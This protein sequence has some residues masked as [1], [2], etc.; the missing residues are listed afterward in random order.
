MSANIS[1]KA[2]ALY[3]A[4]QSSLGTASTL[5]A[6]DI[7]RTSGLSH[8]I[9][10]GQTQTIAYDGQDGR[11]DFEKHVDFWNKYNFE[12]DLV[13]GGDDGGTDILEPPVARFLRACGWD[14]DSTVPNQRTFTLSDRSNIDAI[15]LGSTRRKATNGAGDFEVYRYDTFDARGQ[16]A[17]QFSDDRPKFVFSEFTGKY[18]RPYRIASTPLGTDVPT[19]SFVSPNPL[20]DS[21]YTTLRWKGQ[22]LCTHALSI[23]NMGWTVVGIDR[24]G[25]SEVHLNEQKI[26]IEI[27]FKQTDWENEF[28]PFQEA[29]D[30]Q[31]QN[32]ENFKL[33]CDDRVGHIFKLDATARLKNVQ[34]TDLSDGSVGVTAQLEVDTMTFGWYAE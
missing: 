21:A 11:N 10:D 18:V 6:A 14:M 5:T 33:V 16:A 34:E 8:T 20:I 2:K 30:H 13:G 27:T 15:T 22:D 7:T 23:P 32:Y 19:T 1:A 12:M 17:L 4:L 3:G 24:P 29:E 25:C 26:M 9:Y 31:V 28:N